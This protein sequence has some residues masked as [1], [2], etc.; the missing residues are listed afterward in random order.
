MAE[1]PIDM[2]E[3]VGEMTQQLSSGI[4]PM[5][6]AIGWTVII[7]FAILAVIAIMRYWREKKK[8]MF[9]GEILSALHSIN[10]KLDRLPVKKGKK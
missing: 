6:K 8:L 2:K 4:Y 7:Y 10:S 5:L 1:L 3:V 9:M